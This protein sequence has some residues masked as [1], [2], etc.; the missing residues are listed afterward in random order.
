MLGSAEEASGWGARVSCRSLAGGSSMA[1]VVGSVAFQ[2]ARPS[3]GPVFGQASTK[4][5]EISCQ[6]LSKT[7]ASPC[8]SHFLPVKHWEDFQRP[9][10]PRLLSLA[11]VEGV[12]DSPGISKP[13]TSR[14]PSMPQ[15][16]QGERGLLILLWLWL[17]FLLGQQAHLLH[18]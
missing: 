8:G 13:R 12:V 5:E 14:P 9:W 17:I 16:K 11:V 15:G 18:F 3:M 4:Q 7:S 2:G 6:S 10:T 1:R